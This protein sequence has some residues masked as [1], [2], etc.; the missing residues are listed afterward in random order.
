VCVL[1]LVGLLAA[2]RLAAGGKKAPQ[3]GDKAPA[4]ES[5][6][7]QGKPW[8]SADH[9][10]KKVL[11]LY[12]YPADFTGGC[13]AQA[14]GFRDNLKPLIDKGA[15]VVGVSGD[16]P[17]T[18]AAF[19]KEH[20]LGF[21]L[22]A[23]EKGEVAKKF[24]IPYTAGEKTAKFKGLDFV[25]SGTIQRWTVVIDREGKIAARYQVANAAKDSGKVLEAV[26]KLQKK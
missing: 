20:N 12:F 13:T 9:V 22:L 19:K 23:D 15:E 18:H 11:V 21:T 16:T 24:G 3:V 10:G 8:K 17:K 6:D 7:D 25:R 5:V 26:E 2:G 1:G 14:C 4:F